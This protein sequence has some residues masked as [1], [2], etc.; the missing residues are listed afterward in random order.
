MPLAKSAAS[1]LRLEPVSAVEVRSV[2]ELLPVSRDDPVL[3]LGNVLHLKQVYKIQRRDSLQH[4]TAEQQR[5][6][7]KPAAKRPPSGVAFRIGLWIGRAKRR[8]RLQRYES[9][10]KEI[11]LFVQ[12]KD[13]ILEVQSHLD[14]ASLPYRL[15]GNADLYTD[16]ALHQRE[17]LKTKRAIIREITEK[18]WPAL[19]KSRT[20]P[21]RL[22]KD[23]YF[24][25]VERIFVLLAPELVQGRSKAEVADE[26]EQSWKSDTDRADSMSRDAFFCAM[27]DLADLWV[28]DI[29]EDAY[30][31]FLADLRMRVLDGAYGRRRMCTLPERVICS[32]CNLLCDTNVIVFCAF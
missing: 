17:M 19:L 31:D 26:L 21:E 3:N 24:I 7:V 8:S 9:L 30:V 15:A 5:E 12:Q 6:E 20:D 23:E 13:V 2:E 14:A 16:K 29:D 28:E 10:R 32:I 11:Q 18:W 25:I 27:F 1:D 4:I 22:A